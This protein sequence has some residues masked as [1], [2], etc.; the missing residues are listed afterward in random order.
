[1]T[2]S[3]GGISVA[4]R[5][6]NERIVRSC[7]SPLSST[8]IPSLV[9]HPERHVRGADAV[10]AQHDLVEH[11]AARHPHADHRHRPLLPSPALPPVTRLRPGPR[12]QPGP[13]TASAQPAARSATDVGGPGTSTS[14]MVHWARPSGWRPRRRVCADPSDAGPVGTDADRHRRALRSPAH[15]VF[16]RPEHAR[17]RVACSLANVGGSA[18]PRG[19]DLPAER[20][21]VRRAGLPPRRPGVPTTRR[22]RGMR[23]RPTSSATSAP[24][25]RRARRSANEGSPSCVALGACPTTAH[26]SRTVAPI[27]QSV[28]GG[29]GAATQRVHRR[30]IVGESSRARGDLGADPLVRATLDRRPPR[31]APRG[32]EAAAGT[33]AAAASKIVRQPVQRQRWASSARPTVASSWRSSALNRMMIP[34]VQKPHWLAPVAVKA[35]DPSRTRRGIEAFERRH[36]ASREPPRLASRTRPRGAPSTST[37]QHPHCPWGLHPSF[38]DVMPSWS[39]KRSSSDPA[40]SRTVT[41]APLTR[42]AIPTVTATRIGSV[43]W[44]PS[45]G[46]PSSSAGRG[47][48]GR[49]PRGVRRRRQRIEHPDRRRGCGAEARVGHR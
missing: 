36:V 34:G 43:S 16:T 42:S 2:T 23:A 19:R 44:P 30:R 49:R 45:P 39:R 47:R 41:G 5:I 38:A 28:A 46:G 40:S 24:S 12:A 3:T 31:R 14:S 18:R 17:R 22:S 48:R 10:A 15:D 6:P 7:G 1:M 21:A 29:Q 35:S 33:L 20:T 4:R 11:L 13:P 8:R 9:T 27:A 32:H 37:V 26:A 25:R